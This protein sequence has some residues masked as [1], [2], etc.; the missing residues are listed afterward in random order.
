M[1]NDNETITKIREFNRFY[2][3]MIGLLEKGYLESKF[4]L[5]EVRVLFEIN[6]TKNCTAKEIREKIDIDEGYLSRI[7]DSFVKQKYLVKNH[8]TKDR[9]IKFLSLTEKG[10]TEFLKLDNRSHDAISGMISNL[11]NEEISSL[12]R[13]M[14]KIEMLL[15]KE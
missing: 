5:T 6:Y 8:S 1:K 11:T 15:S 10:K 12:I 4:T 9:R 7:I 3:N 14:D 2:T 13:M